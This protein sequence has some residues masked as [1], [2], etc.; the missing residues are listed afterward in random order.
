MKSADCRRH[1]N[2]RKPLLYYV[3]Y[4][5]DRSPENRKKRT[6]VLPFILR[7]QATITVWKLWQPPTHRKSSTL[8]LHCFISYF[9]S[10]FCQILPIRIFSQNSVNIFRKESQVQFIYF[11]STSRNL[12]CSYLNLSC[13]NV[14]RESVSTSTV[15][16]T[17]QLLFH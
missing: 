15:A 12:P 5:H 10:I 14:V 6:P 17:T 13:E 8:T 2:P 4:D 9:R 7:R 1:S 16:V 3:R 11:L